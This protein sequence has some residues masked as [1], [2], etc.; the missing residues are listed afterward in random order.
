MCCIVM[1]WVGLD[2]VVSYRVSRPSA[3][4]TS[5]ACSNSPPL[6]YCAPMQFKPSLLSDHHLCN[7]ALCCAMEMMLFTMLI[8]VIY[9]MWVLCDISV[10]YHAV[11]CDC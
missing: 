7:A 4:P 10:H 5:A 3:Q 1:D 2:Q 9:I 6:E 8:K 11:D